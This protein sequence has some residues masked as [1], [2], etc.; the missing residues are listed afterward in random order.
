MSK[1][2]NRKKESFLKSIPAM[3][4]ESSQIEM[5]CKF[6]F[7]YFDG[8]QAAGQS[9][10][11]WSGGDGNSSLVELLRKIQH[12]TKSP[13][14]YW[15]EER[16]GRGGLKVLAY[17]DSFPTNSDFTH[18]SHVPHDVTWARFRLGSKVRMIGFVIPESFLIQSSGSS[19]TDYIFD[20]N[21]FYVVF[22]DKHHKFYKTE[23]N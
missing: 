3:D 9:F 7:S 1:F 5:R 20:N 2:S 23:T 18:P 14:S 11:E 22:L 21:T 16:A 13:L 6:N 8:E 4:I 19:K 17:Y 15:R 12:Y 10:E